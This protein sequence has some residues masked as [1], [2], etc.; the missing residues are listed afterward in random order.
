MLYSRLKPEYKANAVRL[1]SEILGC[2]VKYCKKCGPDGD[3]YVAVVFPKLRTG[4]AESNEKLRKLKDA[5]FYPDITMCAA[6]AMEG[7]GM[8]CSS[9][10]V[11]TPE[12][13]EGTW[14]ELKV[15]EAVWQ[16]QNSIL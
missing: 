12:K 7:K 9:A 13:T 15:Q 16:N 8:A 2:K 5:G 3:K 14:A 1:A 11:V 4:D 6:T 10:F